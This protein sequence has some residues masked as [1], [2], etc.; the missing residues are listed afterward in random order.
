MGR[1]SVSVLTSAARACIASAAIAGTL[2]AAAQESQLP[3]RHLSPVEVAAAAAPR[4]PLGPPRIF[5]AIHAARSTAPAATIEEAID[6][7]VVADM[8]ALE[9]PGAQVAVVIDGQLAYQRGYGYKH[10]DNGGEVDFRTVFRVGSLTKQFT[11]AAVLQQAETGTLALDDPITRL[12]PEL[13]LSG[14]W[15]ASDITV[16]HLL[17]H[18]SGFPD[19]W[20]EIDASGEDDALAA[21]ATQQGD[22]RLHAPPGSFWNYTNPGYMLAGLAAERASGVPFRSYTEAEVFAPAGMTSTTFSPNV[23]QSTRNFAYGHF[24]TGGS[25][26]ETFFSPGSYDSAAAAPAGYA[27]STAGDLARWAVLL[28]EGG[29][30]VLSPDSAA[31]LQSA[32]AYMDYIPDLY[33]GYGV[34]RRDYKGVDIV[35]HDGSIPGWGSVLLWAPE[36]RFAVAVLANTSEPLFGAAF[37][38]LEAVLQ[39]EDVPP[40]DYDTDPATW[41]RY[42][43]TY[44]ITDA[45]GSELVA[46]VVLDGDALGVVFPNIESSGFSSVTELLQAYLDTFVL[47]GDGDGVPD[48]EFT[49]VRSS[50]VASRTRWMRNRYAVGERC[51]LPRRSLP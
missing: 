10:R 50:A 23:A 9:T 48:M 7:C 18:T 21:W 46:Q 35:W 19:N 17:T 11:A 43:G 49:F 31:A 6:Q 36:R 26:R 25:G 8:T 29:G 16:R 51:N 1:H 2:P 39:P 33:Y 47:D 3:N 45:F 28:M 12:V 42:T 30:S 15:P 13:H 27:F 41:T 37:G 14:L 40:P 22:V 4:G 20:E 5:P 44:A 32:Q 24:R 34:M 38:I